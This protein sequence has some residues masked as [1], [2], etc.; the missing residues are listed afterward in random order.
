MGILLLPGLALA[1][2]GEPELYNVINCEELNIAIWQFFREGLNYI[3]AVILI[4]TAFAT[5]FRI[6]VDSYT[7][8]KILPSLLL[9]FILANFSHFLMQGLLTVTA[10]LTKTTF[11]LAPDVSIYDSEASEASVIFEP[12]KDFLTQTLKTRLT[13]AYLIGSLAALPLTGATGFL[14]GI[15]LIALFVFIIGLTIALITLGLYLIFL[16]RYWVV[17]V[18]V[19]VS[20]LI[21]TMMAFPPTQGVFRGW[22]NQLFRWLMIKPIAF[23]ILAFAATLVNKIGSQ[24]EVLALMG[25]VILMAA[26]IVIPFR[27]GGAL[28]ARIQSI[29]A[30]TGQAL[31]IGAAGTLGGVAGALQK[32]NR[33][34]GLAKTLRTAQGALYAPEAIKQLSAIRRAQ[35]ERESTGIARRGIARTGAF[36][37]EAAREAELELTAEYEKT[38]SSQDLD[39]ALE[40]AAYSN[41]PHRLAA[42]FN[43]ALKQGKLRFI[44]EGIKNKTEVRDALD[45]S[46]TQANNPVE[47]FQVLERKLGGGEEARSLLKNYQDHLVFSEGQIDYG[48]IINYD[49]GRYYYQTDENTRAA[50]IA[51]KIKNP[52]F[53]GKN[54]SLNH[55]YILDDEGKITDRK[56]LG[57][58][59]INNGMITPGVLANMGNMNNDEIKKWNA[60]LDQISSD[61]NISKELLEARFGDGGSHQKFLARL[62]LSQTDDQA[63][64]FNNLVQI[65]ERVAATMERRERE[66][67]RRRSGGEPGVTTPPLGSNIRTAVRSGETRSPG[68]V[69]L[70]PGTTQSPPFG[71][72]TSPEPTPPSTS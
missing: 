52:E 36:G 31:R 58:Y 59:M 63:A 55:L 35:I 23:A 1:Q 47:L 21:F 7:V 22:F 70:P 30:K 33:A 42:V 61:F 54:L 62:S 37:A 60:N 71:E 2:C 65:M 46:Q 10:S 68:G 3:A 6:N 4:I 20:P 40:E 50:S 38:L 41:D 17:Q 5:T 49:N 66:E 13:Y 32:R 56:A 43:V 14:I 26:A 28:I 48:D 64:P 24:H 34:P 15:G 67:A 8:K 45:I 16:I 11:Y 53:L 9:A 57:Q 44:L 27:L 18:L 19:V 39:R 51:S 29:G 25:L 72:S 12:I 69:I